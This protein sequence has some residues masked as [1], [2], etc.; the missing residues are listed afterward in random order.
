M[1]SSARQRN[2]NSSRF[3]VWASWLE[4]PEQSTINLSAK[5]QGKQQNPLGTLL[6][7]HHLYTSVPAPCHQ[8]PTTIHPTSIYEAPLRMPRTSPRAGDSMKSI[9]QDSSL[10][11]LSLLPTS[12]K[13]NPRERTCCLLERKGRFAQLAKESCADGGAHSEKAPHRHSCKNELGRC[14]QEAC[15]HL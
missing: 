5:Q 15:K 11:L 12:P 14:G 9:P 2:G 13:M 1:H 8:V 3:C 6:I 4:L 10:P 7:F